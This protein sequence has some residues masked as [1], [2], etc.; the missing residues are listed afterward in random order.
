MDINIE[1][2]YKQTEAWKYLE[3]KQTRLCLYGGSVASGKSFLGTLWL[4]NN[5]I[6]YPG[7][8]WVMGRAVLKR[9]QETTLTTFF[10]VAAKMNLSN[11]YEYKEKA[12]VI[13]WKN[14][15][16]ILLKDL[17]YA[18][19][20]PNFDS[21]G[22]LEVC[23]AFCDEVAEISYKAIQVLS[24]RLRYKLKQFGIIGKILATCNPSKNWSY[25]E[26]Y[27]PW[28]EDK[29]PDHIRFIQALPSDN[30]HLDASY[31]ESLQQLPTA[32]KQRLLYGLWEWGEEDVLFDPEDF[33]KVFHKEVTLDGDNMFIT[34]DVARLGND[35]TVVTIW[36][37]LNCFE[38]HQYEKQTLN[39]TLDKV[40]ALRDKYN[41]PSKNIIIDATGIGAG[42]VDGLGATE[43]IAG[44]KS[45]SGGYSNIKTEAYFKLSEMFKEHRI[46][47]VSK[48][49]ELTTKLM[50][51]LEV[52]KIKDKVEGKLYMTS[53]DEVKKMIG[54][55]PDF[56]DAISMRMLPEIKP[57]SQ[58]GLPTIKIKPFKE[59]LN[60]Y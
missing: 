26:V 57:K 25:T 4:I 59:G 39:I 55:S 3:D 11:Y 5:C 22:S 27:K 33:P 28:K 52:L 48:D 29:L 56:A 30:P 47:I 1:L 53:K 21:L 44:G 42:I 17:A 60:Y 50:Q 6:K 51:E 49:P 10:E 38:I 32:I 8:R 34:V 23:G 31:L 35:S 15:S 12:G 54:R 40:R 43:F 41:V 37:G 45:P 13:K 14:G 9:L 19:S 46:Q 18:P 7:S 2:N 20:D 58:F 24:T 36:S 16:E